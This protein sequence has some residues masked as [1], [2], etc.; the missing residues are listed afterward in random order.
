MGYLICPECGSIYKSNLIN[1]KYMDGYYMPCPRS[2]CCGY[3]F[4]CDELLILAILELNGKG[5]DTQFCC[6][7]HASEHGGGY[8]MFSDYMYELT[9]NL[10]DP[11]EGWHWEDIPTIHDSTNG[12]RI[13][14]STNDGK[15]MREKQIII[16]LN[17]NSLMNWAYNLEPLDCE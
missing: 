1:T 9:R 16:T 12:T 7:G 8:V 10:P 17:A 6:A 4:E 2:N 13:L 5:Y 14:R 11:P 15:D 3:I